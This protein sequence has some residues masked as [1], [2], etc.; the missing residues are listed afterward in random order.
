MRAREPKVIVWITRAYRTEP[1]VYSD[2]NVRTVWTISDVQ[3]LLIF[4]HVS[5]TQIA[6]VG[7]AHI[8]PA[9]IKYLIL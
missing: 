7:V 3:R 8:A 5:C 1:N 6:G 4:I 2:I 9:L